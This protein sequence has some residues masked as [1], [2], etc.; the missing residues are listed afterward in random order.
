MASIT[1]MHPAYFETAFRVG[2][3]TPAWPEVFAIITAYAT[4]GECW[5]A[6]VNEAADE[7]LR[8][9]LS[10]RGVLIGRVTG[11]SPATGHA[12][13]GWAAALDWVAACDIGLAYRQDAVFIVQGDQLSVTFCDARRALVP[14][15]PFRE[16]LVTENSDHTCP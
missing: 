13:P 9:D 6:E 14:V 8:A 7:R 11:F 3:P 2:T 10:V 15:G 12:E 4:T 16:R 1:L 5:S